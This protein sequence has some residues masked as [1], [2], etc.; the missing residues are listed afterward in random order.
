LIGL[1]SGNGPINP[2]NDN[3]IVTGKSSRRCSINVLKLPMKV[4]LGPALMLEGFHKRL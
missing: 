3:N 1:F 2:A 4:I